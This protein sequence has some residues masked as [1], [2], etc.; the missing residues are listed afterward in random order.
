MRT[1]TS[2]V[3]NRHKAWGDAIPVEALNTP[4]F[5]ER[6]ATVS[7][8]GSLL[9][10][11]SNREPGGIGRLDL[12]VS[13]RMDG[14][15]DSSEEWSSPMNLGELVNT[16]ADDVGPAYF[17]DDEGN[18]FLYFTSNRLGGPGGFDIYLSAIGADGSFGMPLLV[19]ELS[20]TSNDARPAIRADGL[21]VVFQSN[22]VPSHGLAD[23]W[24]STRETVL[25]PWGPAVNLGAAVNTELNDRQAALSDDGESL[26][27]ASNRVGFGSDDIWTSTR[28]KTKEG[29]TA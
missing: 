14:R 8:D 4:T 7:R 9:F 12:Y 17:E 23:L 20:S 15:G 21:E 19:Q 10:F 24:V 13:R 11:S 27:F 28:D 3:G 22:R 6:N 18:A 29:V 1:S 25:A 26:F 5:H 2:R 16:P